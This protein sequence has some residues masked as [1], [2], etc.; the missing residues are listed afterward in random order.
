MATEHKYAQVLRWIADGKTVQIRWGVDLRW[1]ALENRNEIVNDE[2]LRG[3]GDYEFRLKPRTVKIG[4]REVE[5]PVLEP[6][7]GQKLWYW[8]TQEGCASS[9][10]YGAAFSASAKE[11]EFFSSEDAASCAYSAFTALLRGES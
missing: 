3:A 7:E 5:V 6:V 8:N 9:V 11:G 2:I 1:V 10:T 4:S